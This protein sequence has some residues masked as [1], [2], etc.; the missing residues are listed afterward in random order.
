MEILVIIPTYNERENI[1]SLIRGILS[2][3]EAFSVLV[4]DDGSPDGTGR[5]VD[6]LA[7]R[8]DDRVRILHRPEKLGLGSA[9]LDGFRFALRHGYDAVCEM[10]ADGS[11]DPAVLPSFY[12]QLESGADVVIGS[13]R[14]AGGAIIGWGW[15]RHLMSRGAMWVSRLAL[16][17]RTADVTSGFRCYR[18]A[19][20]RELLTCDIRGSSYAFQEETLFH[21]E[22]LGFRVVEIPIVFSDRKWGRSKLTRKDVWQFFTVIWQLRG[23]EKRTGRG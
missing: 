7:A 15:H 10:D 14:V 4:V 19:V 3:G 18:S 1:A 12:R 6:S 13:R 21:C 20:I 17:L 2:Q 22:R 23:L 5:I 16:G 11:H 8:L 9:Y